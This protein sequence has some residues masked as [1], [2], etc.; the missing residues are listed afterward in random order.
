MSDYWEDRA[1][2]DMYNHMKDAD[3][4]ADLIAKIYRNASMQITF[5]A[6]DIFE[7]YMIKHKISEREA[8]ELINTMQDRDSIQEL[9]LKLKNKDPDKTRQE[10]IREPVSYTHLTLPTTERV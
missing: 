1:A 9:I 8:W 6:E 2:W 7:R 10:L 5:A 4:R 3:E